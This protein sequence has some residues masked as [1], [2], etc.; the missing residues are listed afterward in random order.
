MPL[1]EAV[2][3]VVK[4]FD[5]TQSVHARVEDTICPFCQLRTQRDSSPLSFQRSRATTSL[6]SRK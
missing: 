3:G 6:G 5:V 1:Y 2:A 4:Q